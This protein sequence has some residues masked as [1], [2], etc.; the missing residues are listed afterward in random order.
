MPQGSVLGPIL[1][2]LYTS[3]IRDLVRQ[4]KVDYHLY[5]DDTQLYVSFQIKNNNDQLS[6]ITACTSDIKKSILHNLLKLND[7]K[8]EV[9]LISSPH[10]LRNVSKTTVTIGNSAINSASHVRNLGA[11]FDSSLSMDKF[12]SQKY[13]ARMLHLGYIS[14]IRK[15][16]S[17]DV[18]KSVIHALV[19]SRLD[20]ANSLLLGINQAHINKL[21]RIQ[22][23]ATKIICKATYRDHVTPYL[24]SLHWLPVHARIQFKGLVNTYNFFHGTAPKYLSDLVKHYTLTRSLRSENQ[25]KLVETRYGDHSFTNAA[26]VLWNRLPLKIKNAESVIKFKKH[27][28]TFLFTQEYC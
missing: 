27:L 20:Y 14:C 8:T 12:V 28:K 13:Q 25:L 4:H 15:Y 10:H 6:R 1:F 18:C 3:P 24:I 19:T 11:T 5:A 17:I 7:D 26:P 21:Q 23:Y 16:L 9:L 22:N 2:S